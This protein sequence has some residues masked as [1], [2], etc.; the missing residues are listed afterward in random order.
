MK[1]KKFEKKLALNKK[2]IVNLNN[3]QLGHVKGGCVDTYPSCP[4]TISDDCVTLRFTGCAVC[5]TN[6]CVTCVTCDTCWETH[7]SGACC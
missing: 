2:T 1:S 5:P 4:F 3:G 6:T 7:C